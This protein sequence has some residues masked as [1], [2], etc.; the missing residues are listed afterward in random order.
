MSVPTKDKLAVI[1]REKI[2]AET[3]LATGGEA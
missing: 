2:E 3:T 1:T